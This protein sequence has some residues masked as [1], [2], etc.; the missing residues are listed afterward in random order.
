MTIGKKYEIT[1]EGLDKLQNELDE[2]KNKMRKK[3]QDQLDAEIKAGDISENTQYYRIQDE[4]GSNDKRIEELELLINTAVLFKA[5]AST[6]LIA[7]L[8]STVEL[9]KD[10]TKIQYKLV[11]APEADPTKNKI[12]IESP[13]GKAL[14][15]KKKGDEI[16]VKT[17]MGEVK[18]TVESVN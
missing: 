8:G 14:D 11:S 5:S 1:K 7:G 9:K 13:M 6:S 17:P 10:G 3:L 18:Y 2:R 4:I 15:G 16:S 12:S